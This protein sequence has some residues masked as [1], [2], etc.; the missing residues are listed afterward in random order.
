MTSLSP[1]V[2]LATSFFL[3]RKKAS[4]L[5][6]RTL[7][8]VGPNQEA[9]DAATR[10]AA[11]CAAQAFH[12][13]EAQSLAQKPGTQGGSPHPPPFAPIRPHSSREALHVRRTINQKL[14]WFL[15]SAILLFKTDNI[16]KTRRLLN[17]PPPSGGKHSCM[18]AL[19]PVLTFFLRLCR[20]GLEHGASA[21][22]TPR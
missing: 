7:G 1:I 14:L 19:F 17:H 21:P 8:R 22:T 3:P 11:S 4:L 6:G 5:R 9:F 13:V 15:C 12:R 16:I 10:V 20:A 2:F 18:A